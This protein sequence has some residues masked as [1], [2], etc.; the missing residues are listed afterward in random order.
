MDSFAHLREQLLRGGIA[1]RHVRRYLR[2]LSEHLADLTAAQAEAGFDADDAAIRA[3][4]ALGP[5]AELADA[6]LKQRDFRSISARFPWLVYGLLPPL[7]VSLAFFLLLPVMVTLGHL[8]GAFG[9]K[10]KLVLPVP[11][12]F[13]STMSGLVL[14]ANLLIGTGLAFL[15]A[16]MAQRQRMKLVWPLLSMALILVL[17]VRGNFRVGAHGISFT[18]ETLLVSYRGFGGSVFPFHWP[19]FLAQ[20]AVL[21]LPLGWLLRARRE[22]AA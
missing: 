1:P 12:W 3:R 22:T 13:D 14:A 2:E 19:I 9:P 5:D 10:N 4:A 8:G 7:L 17:G 6:M 15:L 16:H 20:A 18:L 11:G 21:C